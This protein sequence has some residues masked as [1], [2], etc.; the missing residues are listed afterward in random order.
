MTQTTYQ[1]K[2]RQHTKPK[3]L[4]R[5]GIVPA[6]IFGA[7]DSIAIQ[8]D[9]LSFGKLYE[10]V[11]ETGLI[12]VEIKGD[13]HQHPVLVEEIQTDPVSGEL[14]HASLRQVDLTEKTEANVPVETIGEF[15]IPEAV[16]VVVKDEIEVEALPAD[17]PEKFEIDVSLLTEV[18]Q[19]VTYADLKYDRSKVTLVLGEE[20][21]EEPV[22]LVQEQREEEPEEEPEVVEGEEGEA[23]EGEAGEADKEGDQETDKKDE[24]PSE[25][26]TEDVEKSTS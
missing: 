17:L 21:E 15:D 18:G 11:G 4:R 20:G 5:E 16:L 7:G 23:T 22:V 9:S 26:T 19:M 10:Q 13:K 3:Q 12:Y 1:V 25:K 24:K 2:K 8:V 14:L 6:N